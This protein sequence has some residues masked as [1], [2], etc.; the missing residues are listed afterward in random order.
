MQKHVWENNVATLSLKYIVF[1]WKLWIIWEID[2]IYT[3]LKNI[4]TQ[5]MVSI[6]EFE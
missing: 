3:H 6:I 2:T 1:L 5:D 4:K